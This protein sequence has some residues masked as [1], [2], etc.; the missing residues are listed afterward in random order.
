MAVIIDGTTSPYDYQSYNPPQTTV[1]EWQLSPEASIA[2]LVCLPI[3]ALLFFIIG[4]LV[5]TE[6]ARAA[7]RKKKNQNEVQGA[8]GSHGDHVALV[9]L[10]VL[11]VNG[12][13]N[14]VGINPGQ[15][16]QV[17]NPGQVGIVGHAAHAA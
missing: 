6:R 14:Q 13:G 15:D 12:D 4:V 7:A 10:P 9:A 3:A 2:V 5:G 17:E 8:G 16:G 1:A 11:P